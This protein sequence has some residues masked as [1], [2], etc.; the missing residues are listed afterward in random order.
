MDNQYYSSNE[1]VTEKVT[2]GAMINCDDAVKHPKH[3]MMTGGFESFDVIVESL[4]IEG[5]RYFCQG[6]ILKYQIR[7][8]YKNGEE[9]LEKRHWY[10]KMDQL[11]SQCKSIEDYYATKFQM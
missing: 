3:Y 7:Y 10:S 9:D 4:G 6:N 2:K 11:L 8:H 1:D 5:A